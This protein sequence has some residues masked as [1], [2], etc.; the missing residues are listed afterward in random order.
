MK[1]ISNSDYKRLNAYPNKIR[2]AAARVGVILAEIKPRLDAALEELNEERAEAEGFI[3]DLLSVGEEYFDGRSEKWRGDDA[4]S[5]YSSWLDDIRDLESKVGA[6]FDLP[7][8][9]GTFEQEVASV[10]EAI[11][12][13]KQAP[14]Q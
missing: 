2:E 8:D 9:V 4:G 3:A 1:Q 14:D 6:D 11:E 5:Q 13:L 12:D 10:A 7:I